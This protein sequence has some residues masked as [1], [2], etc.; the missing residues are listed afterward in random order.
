MGLNS[1]DPVK[2]CTAVLSSLCETLFSRV[3]SM[4]QINKWKSE[5]FVFCFTAFHAHSLAF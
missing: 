5:S 4:D 1:L 2:S 3:H